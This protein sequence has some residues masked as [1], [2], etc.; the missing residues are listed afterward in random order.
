MTLAVAAVESMS[1]VFPA[2][3]RYLAVRYLG[4]GEIA[5][6]RYALFLA[7]VPPGMLVVTF[8]AAAFP[9]ISDMANS[10]PEKLSGFYRETLRLVVFVMAPLALALYLFAPEVISVAFRR[11][12]FDQQ[13]VAQT[14]GPLLC[15]ALGLVF[16]GI[17]FYQIRYYYARNL[18]R[19]LA[20]ILGLSLLLKLATSA[21]FVRFLGADGLALST[22]LAWLTTSVVMTIDLARNHGL[23]LSTD[24]AGWTGRLLLSSVVTGAV[25]FSIKELLPLMPDTGLTMQFAWL[26]LAGVVGLVVYVVISFAL[27]MP[28]PTRVWETL[29]SRFSRSGSPR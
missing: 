3:D 2:I 14:T 28:E 9:W 21:I 18:L 15:Y 5:A 26:I 11:G 24:I 20:L 17:Y 13:S 10:Q 19:R 22:S 29:R 23:R 16:Y 8:S 25:W 6:L 1:L 7:Q 4:D 27:R 12:A